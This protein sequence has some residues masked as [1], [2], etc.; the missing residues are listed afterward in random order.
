[1]LTLELDLLETRELFIKI[2]RKYNGLRV[3]DDF[4]RLL[5][6]MQSTEIILLEH[7]RELSLSISRSWG[8]KAL[9]TCCNLI[10]DKYI[11]IQWPI[12][13]KNMDGE[14]ERI[15]LEYR[16]LYK[17]TLYRGLHELVSDMCYKE[18]KGEI[19]CWFGGRQEMVS[20]RAVNV[21]LAMDHAGVNG[22]VYLDQSEDGE[23]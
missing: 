22:G 19:R 5:I 14:Y 20:L 23:L 6:A 17:M 21:W 7:A 4:S 11:R 1:M 3:G 9:I 8:R 15:D 12:D 16:N 2:T 13:R 18:N 10:D